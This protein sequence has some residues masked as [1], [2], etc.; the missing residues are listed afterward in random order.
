MQLNLDNGFFYVGNFSFDLENVYFD[1]DCDVFCID[2]YGN[3]WLVFIFGWIFVLLGMEIIE[4]ELLD[5]YI[6]EL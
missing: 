4:G 3:L 2:W 5:G 1:Y 6:C